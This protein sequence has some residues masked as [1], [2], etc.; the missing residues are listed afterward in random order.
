MLGVNTSIT[1]W[2][3]PVD[4]LKRRL[5]EWTADE[6]GNVMI[7]YAGALIPLLMMIGGAVDVAN[8]YAARAKLQNAC[9][10]AVLAGRQSM[11]GNAWSDAVEVEADKFF[12][13]NFPAGTN[14][15]LSQSFAIEQNETD[16]A[17]LLG[18]ASAVIPTI[19]M[20]IFGFE[21]LTAGVECNAK[22]D[23]GHNDVMLVLDTTGSMASAPSIGGDSKI[24]RLRE[25]AAGIFR[26]LDDSA[27]GSITR[28]GIVSYS[29]TVNVARSLVTNDILRSQTYI[30]GSWDYIYCDSNGHQIWNCQNR[31]SETKPNS[32]L[33]N[34]NKKYTY[35]VT[36][37]NEEIGRAHV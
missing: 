33:S 10:A 19:V 1:C 28:F 32:G 12:D 15:A 26:A 9:D 13:F 23:L 16:P 6:S 25:G 17:E 2:G 24:K 18:D 7:M 5:A 4:R 20:H 8:F 31:N 30:D 22:R 27:N 11:E 21:T 29:H 14:R 3:Q 35:N 36:F 34:G 37:R